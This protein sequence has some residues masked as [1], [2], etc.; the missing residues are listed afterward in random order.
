M[1]TKLMHTAGDRPCNGIAQHASEAWL[2]DLRN[3]RTVPEMQDG[4]TV[5][6]AGVIS[7]TCQCLSCSR[8]V[9]TDDLTDGETYE[10]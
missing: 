10:P 4:D 5:I 3:G 1:I 8:I 9:G 6:P 7:L 2:S